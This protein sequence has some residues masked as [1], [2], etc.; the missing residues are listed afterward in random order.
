MNKQE[1]LEKIAPVFQTVFNDDELEVTMELTSDEI[2]EWSS[3]TQTLLITNL[4]NLFGIKFK[5]REIATMNDVATIVNLIE[6]KLG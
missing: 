2:D 5:L 4:E 3:I 6:S 1:I